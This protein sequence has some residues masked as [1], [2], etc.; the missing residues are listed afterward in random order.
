MVGF[1]VSSEAGTIPASAEFVADHPFIFVVRNVDLNETLLIGR[2]V[3]P[4][5]LGPTEQSDR[6]RWAG[7]VHR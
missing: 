6:V 5:R 3:D 4:K 7:Y 1:L 2:V